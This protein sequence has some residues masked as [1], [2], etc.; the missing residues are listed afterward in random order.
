MQKVD[1]KKSV[2]YSLDDTNDE[3]P[4]TPQLKY[5]I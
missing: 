2:S 5:Y 3:I 4:S 1:F